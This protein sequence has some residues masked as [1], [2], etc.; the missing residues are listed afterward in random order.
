MQDTC[1]YRQ[2]MLTVIEPTYVW[3]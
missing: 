2:N 3:Q 1:I